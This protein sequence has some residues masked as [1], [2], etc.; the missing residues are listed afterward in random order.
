MFYDVALTVPAN[1]PASAP[2]TQDVLFVP[3]TIHKVDVEFPHGCVGLVHTL[4][5]RGAHQVWPS[6]IDGDFAGNNE[7]ITWQDEYDLAEAPFSLRLV[8]WNLD[9]FY[10]HTVTWRF[11]LRGFPDKQRREAAQKLYELV[12]DAGE[13]A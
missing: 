2:V 12:L 3:G 11:A 13:E 8:G 4:V 1:T 7:T 9:D 10:D 5:R 6:N